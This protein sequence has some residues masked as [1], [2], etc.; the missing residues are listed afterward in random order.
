M[1]QLFAHEPC[2]RHLQE[3]CRR[4]TAALLVF[5]QRDAPVEDAAAAAAVV[6]PALKEKAEHYLTEK[7]QQVQTR[8][9]FPF[10]DTLFWSFAVVH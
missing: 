1:H 7:Q 4:P 10:L 3:P 5:R 9:G 6:P 8:Q 2:V